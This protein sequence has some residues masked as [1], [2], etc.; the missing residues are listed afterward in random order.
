M[1]FLTFKAKKGYT[2]LMKN[3]KKNLFKRFC[4]GVLGLCFASV[5]FLASGCVPSL[6]GGDWINDLNE[7]LEN[8][9]IT[10]EE[11]D[12]LFNEYSG[13][14]ELEGIKVLRRPKSYD[15]DGNVSDGGS[16]YYYQFSAD[17]FKY[18]TYI[19]GYTN[20]NGIP[21]GDEEEWKENLRENTV[22]FYD[23]LRYQISYKEYDTEDPNYLKLGLDKN[24]GW[25]FCK[26][27]LTI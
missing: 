27:S 20:I 23:S 10:Q 8:G 13:G 19:Y 17:I 14:V 25:N 22:Y 21:F 12:R 6:L 16:N 15:Y 4:S 26:D 3:K 1:F 24:K 7:Q 11:Y 2:K 5:C 9:E 18:L